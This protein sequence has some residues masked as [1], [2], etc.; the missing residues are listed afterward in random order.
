MVCVHAMYACGVQRTAFGSQLS[1]YNMWYLDLNL[2]WQTWWHWAISPTDTFS[3]FDLC[4]ITFSCIHTW[5]HH[6][7]QDRKN[8]MSQRPPSTPV[9]CSVPFLASPTKTSASFV[10]FVGM[11]S[12]SKSPCT[13]LLSFN[14][15][16]HPCSIGFSFSLKFYGMNIL[17]AICT[18]DGFVIS[19]FWFMNKA[20]VMARA[21]SDHNHWGFPSWKLGPQCGDMEEA[22]VFSDSLAFKVPNVRYLGHYR[23]HCRMS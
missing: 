5:N 10:V 16:V 17:Q 6:L 15:E 1:P 8:L 20:A 18:T 3:A 4:P 14:F 9:T 12:H 22:E 21:W 23:I 19:N 7:D 2:G 13:Q 11:D